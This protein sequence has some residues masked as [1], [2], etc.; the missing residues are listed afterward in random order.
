MLPAP[1][2]VCRTSELA[3]AGAFVTFD[4][5]ENPLLVTRDAQGTIR[6]MVNLCRHRGV[7]LV[8]EKRGVQKTFTCIMH[9]WTYDCEGQM[10]GMPLA[11]LAKSSPMLDAI[12]Q[13]SALVP[14]ASELRHGF[15]WV[16]PGGAA[17]DVAAFLGPLDAELA[18]LTEHV[19][20]RRSETLI[21]D[22]AFELGDAMLRISR[23]TMLVRHAGAASVLTFSRRR[24]EDDF[25]ER[26]S[27]FGETLTVDHVLLAPPGVEAEDAWE[28]VESVIARRSIRFANDGG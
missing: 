21:G 23:D 19:A 16:S 18:G 4:T 22:D 12:R 8:H 17:I 26:S 10:G 24:G 20:W 15:V 28:R 7:R 14:L 27:I 9:G 2:P 1:I 25:G 5:E 6:A 13:T 11:R 3:E